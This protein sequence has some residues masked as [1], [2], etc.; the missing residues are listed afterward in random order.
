[1]STALAKVAIAG[2][3][4][5][6]TK[7]IF[8]GKVWRRGPH[9]RSR[10]DGLHRKAKFPCRGRPGDPA[11]LSAI[12]PGILVLLGRVADDWLRPAKTMIF[13]MFSSDYIKEI[14]NPIF[15]GIHSFKMKRVSLLCKSSR[16]L[17]LRQSH[18]HE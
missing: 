1:M 14:C 16:E 13:A 3:A 11:L 17:Y 15:P 7:N 8:N 6:E 4:G 12:T 10:P 5:W 9:C 2:D 18:I